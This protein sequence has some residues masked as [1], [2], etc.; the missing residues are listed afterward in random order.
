MQGLM[1]IEDAD[2]EECENMGVAPCV[3]GWSQEGGEFGK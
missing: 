2:R 1:K 3:C